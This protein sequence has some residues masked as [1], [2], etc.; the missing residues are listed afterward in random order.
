MRG[1][2]DKIAESETWAGIRADE[3]LAIM[4]APLDDRPADEALSVPQV[5]TLPFVV[6]AFLLSAGH[7]ENEQWTDMLDRAEAAIEK[8]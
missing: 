3:A 5:M 1:I 7:E 2:A 8:G 6:A 4:T